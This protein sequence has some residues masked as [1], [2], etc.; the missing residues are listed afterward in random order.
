MHLTSRAAVR[1]FARAGQHVDNLGGGALEIALASAIHT[2][3]NEAGS[4]TD[5]RAQALTRSGILS[6]LVAVT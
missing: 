6:R 4:T 3:R 5:G 1:A 2:V